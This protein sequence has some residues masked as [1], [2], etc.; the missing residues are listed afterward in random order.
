M[1]VITPT[2]LSDLGKR[3][4]ALEEAI[5]DHNVRLVIIDSVAHLARAEFGRERVVQ[6]QSVWAPWRR[7]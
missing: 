4:D 5:I 6:R 2:S 3:L 1:Q 7:C